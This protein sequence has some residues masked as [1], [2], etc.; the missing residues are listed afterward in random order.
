MRA[1]SCSTPR[2]TS[3]SPTSRRG[4]SS[5]RELNE[6]LGTSAAA[7]FPVQAIGDLS[8]RELEVLELVAAGLTNE[9]ISA[10]SVPQRSHGRAP[11]VE[12]LREAGPVRARRPALRLR[13]RSSNCEGQPASTRA[14]PLW[15][16]AAGRARAGWVLAPMTTRV[17]R[18][19]DRH[20]FDEALFQQ[21]KR[22]DMARNLMLDA[23]TR[24]SGRAGSGI[25]HSRR[26]RDHAS[27]P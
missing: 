11:S 3:C 12:H 25:R 14:E 24:D 26:R 9:A 16:F 17:G 23:G 2:T 7:A 5:S 10:A 13:C 8:P 6:F 15:V 20:A 27:R 4:S 22:C 1:W 21:V 19:Y 18:T